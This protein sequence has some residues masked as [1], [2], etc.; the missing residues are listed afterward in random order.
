MIQP[1]MLD[2][3]DERQRRAARVALGSVTR[4]NVARLRRERSLVA[5]VLD[6]LRN[7]GGR[8]G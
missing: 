4:T 3:R 7:W 6:K 2:I 8:R 1:L 5:R